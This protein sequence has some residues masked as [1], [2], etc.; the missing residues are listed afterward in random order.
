MADSIDFFIND[1]PYATD[2]TI[3]SVADLLAIA[4]LSADR[5]F[6]ISPD[7]TKRSNPEETVEIQ[8]GDLFTTEKRERDPKPEPSVRIHYEVNGERQATAETDLSVERILRMAGKAAS[9]DLQQMESY[10]LENINTGKRYQN[11]SDVV[12]VVNGDQ[13][14]AVH[15]GATPVAGFPELM[16]P[17]DLIC[18]EFREVGLAPLESG[19]SRVAPRLIFRRSVVFSCMQFQHNDR[20]YRL[21]GAS[22]SAS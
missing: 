19:I 9:I 18:A 6:L 11:L 15:S 22:P 1:K 5:F 21:W 7:G 2:K 3:Q 20:E 12:N 14:L 8:T 17:T 13:F 16:E 10:I 4:D